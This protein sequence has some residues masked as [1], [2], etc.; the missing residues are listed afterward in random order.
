MCNEVDDGLFLG[1]R[2][3]V[4]TTA[5]YMYFL[6]EQ[7]RKKQSTQIRASGMYSEAKEVTSGSRLSDGERLV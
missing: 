1:S 6:N 2:V 3:M 4:S 5:D 7:K